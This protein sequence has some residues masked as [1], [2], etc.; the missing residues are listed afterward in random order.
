MI[1]VTNL[2]HL[3][4]L[5]K[6]N[7]PAVLVLH[8]WRITLLQFKSE[9]G[10]YELIG[11]NEISLNEGIVERENIINMEEFKNALSDLFS[12]AKPEAVK[13]NQLWTNIPYDLLFTFV[14]DFSHKSKQSLDESVM[15][16]RVKEHSPIPAE[17]L[18]LQ[19][20]SVEKGHNVTC[21][22]YASP[23]KWEDRLLK[24]CKDFGINSIKFIPEPIAHL[25]LADEKNDG[26]FALFSC[27]EERIF[28]TLFRN[29]LIHDSYFLSDLD[30]P[31]S[32]DCEVCFAEFQIA[33]DEFVNRFS[34]KLE[35]LYFVGFA[36]NQITAIK[37]YFKDQDLPLN[38]LDG[39]NS[40]LNSL[41]PYEPERASLF[42]LFNVL[43]LSQKQD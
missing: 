32:L 36:K 12:Q 11:F 43:V 39:K 29:G 35:S 5:F 7:L 10:V 33:Q 16:N 2:L 25:S 22:A 37:K 28:L 18:S 27:H 30:D 13:A 24:A 4:S 21:S 17:E 15:L 34:S 8:D 41:M 40:G 6:K 1:L 14:E 26:N 31:S 19:Y 9:N 20:H 38:F 42:G 23:K 3:F